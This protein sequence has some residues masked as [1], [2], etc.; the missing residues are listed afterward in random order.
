MIKY[1]SGVQIHRVKKELF[2]NMSKC[3]HNLCMCF[4]HMKVINGTHGRLI[5]R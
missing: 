4:V 3:S 5:G 2:N 1:S